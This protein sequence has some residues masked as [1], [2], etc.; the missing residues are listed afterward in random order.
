M[1]IPQEMIQKWAIERLMNENVLERHSDEYYEELGRM[2]YLLTDWES[3]RQGLLMDAY[4]P[5]IQ[6]D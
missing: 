6:V 1:K 5:R 4:P 3:E 2:V